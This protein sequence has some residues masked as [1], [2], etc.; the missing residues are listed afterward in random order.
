MFDDDELTSRKKRRSKLPG[1]SES[2]FKQ[3]ENSSLDSGKFTKKFADNVI[4]P[5]RGGLGIEGGSRGPIRDQRGR[6]SIDKASF[7]G[8]IKWTPAQKALILLLSGGS[9][10]GM[11]I[12]IYLTG[13][14]AVAVILGSVIMLLFLFTYIIHWITKG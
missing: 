1:D 10:A 3:M 6:G 13:N 11:I 5:K 14:K 8:N 9:Y 4:G 12:A 2:L 7:I